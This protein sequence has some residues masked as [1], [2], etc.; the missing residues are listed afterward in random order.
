[1]HRLTLWV[2]NVVTIQYRHIINNIN[3]SIKPAL[4]FMESH[5]VASPETVRPIRTEVHTGDM[6]RCRGAGPMGCCLW[7]PAGGALPPGGWRRRPP[8]WA[9]WGSDPP[10]APGTPHHSDHSACAPPASGVR[11]GY[12]GEGVRKRGE[13]Y[14]G[15]G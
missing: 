3:N 4:L 9:V 11:G 1:M 13:R 10:L 8:G 14:R 2:S 7:R 6:A 5:S 12:E 15:G